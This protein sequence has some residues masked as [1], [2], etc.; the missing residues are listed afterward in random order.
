MTISVLHDCENEEEN[1]EKGH[2]SRWALLM[3]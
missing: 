3:S 1:L 2:A